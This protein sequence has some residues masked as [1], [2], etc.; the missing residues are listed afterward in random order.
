MEN[1]SCNN[2]I[3]NIICL[4]VLF[5]CTVRWHACSFFSKFSAHRLHK[6]PLDG[7]RVFLNFLICTRQAV[8]RPADCSPDW[9]IDNIVKSELGIT[10]PYISLGLSFMG[11]LGLVKRPR[12]S[13]LD[14][15]KSFPRGK[16]SL[17]TH[18][19]LQYY[20]SQLL[21]THA[22]ETEQQTNS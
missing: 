6:Q 20:T 22:I 11:S 18:D 8:L 15:G 19:I 16:R 17:I 14:T 10:E 4:N 7:G 21:H 2:V 3:S 9:P 13:L 12:Y 5:F 1:R